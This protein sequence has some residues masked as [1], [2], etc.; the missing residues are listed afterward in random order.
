MKF[1]DAQDAKTEFSQGVK[2][3]IQK[4]VQYLNKTNFNMFVD[5][6]LFA[7][8]RSEIKHAMAASIELL[9]IILNFPEVEKRQDAL[10]SGKSFEFVCS[11]KKDPTRYSDKYKID[12]Y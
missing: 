6:Y 1:S 12:E 2:D 8:I 7:Q 5:E 4:G 9:Y 11:Y 3:S 10:G